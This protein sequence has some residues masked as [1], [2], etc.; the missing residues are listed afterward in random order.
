MAVGFTEIHGYI[1]S[2][3]MRAFT[4]LMIF[5]MVAFQSNVD[6]RVVKQPCA[7]EQG[8]Q[9]EMHDS[10]ATR[11]CCNDEET[12]AKTGNL[13]KTGQECNL[14]HTFT[15]VSLQAPVQAPV[16]TP[17]VPAGNLFSPS[18]NPP[19]IWRPPTFS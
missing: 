12:A 8:M 1:C 7:M 5:F 13:C 3:P 2:I 19:D 11:D 4:A 14:P 10:A 6:A 15:L 16:A 9:A 18:F 17:V